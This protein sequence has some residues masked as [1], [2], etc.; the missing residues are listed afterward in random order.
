[1]STLRVANLR[2]PSSVSD[3]IILNAN[4]TCEVQGVLPTEVAAEVKAVTA[5]LIVQF[6]I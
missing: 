1:M 4:G 3:N 6:Y 5:G 2:H